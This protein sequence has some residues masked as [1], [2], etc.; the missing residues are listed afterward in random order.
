MI[1]L[2]LSDHVG[3]YSLSLLYTVEQVVYLALFKVEIPVDL[4]ILPEIASKFDPSLSAD[5]IFSPLPN[6]LSW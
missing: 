2:L 3:Q 4:L 5:F 6:C 1:F